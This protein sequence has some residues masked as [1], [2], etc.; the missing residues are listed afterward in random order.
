MIE[1]DNRACRRC[2]H[3]KECRKW[4]VEINYDSKYCKSKRSFD[5]DGNKNTKR[6]GK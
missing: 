3:V 6:R 2:N 1:E 5:K 4:I